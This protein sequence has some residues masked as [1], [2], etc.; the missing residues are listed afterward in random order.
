MIISAS[1]R[2]D[3]P[4]YY[5]EW[6]LNRIK[7]GYLYVRNPMNPRQVSRISLSPEVVDCIV[8]WTKNPE[9]MLA[10]LEELEAYSYYFQF[11]LTGYGGD[12][13]RNV[14]HKKRRMIPVF[15]ELSRRIGKER[16]IWRY[17]PI[18][19]TD[20][21]TPAYHLKAFA[22]IAEAL[23]GC[24]SKCVVSFVDSYVRNRQN[25]K[26]LRAFSLPEKELFVFAKEIAHIAGAHHMTVVS[27]AETM[28]LSACGIGHSC[29]IDK[30]LI[31]QIIGCKI[32]AGKDRNQRKECGCIESVEIGAYDTCRNGC[33]Y[34]YANSSPERVLK[35]SGLYDA[36]APL[37]CGQI[38]EE[39]IVTERKM[40]SLKCGDEI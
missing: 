32:R 29:C 15:Q 39:D 12:I 18:L 5:A 7:E 19:F 9:P 13:E 38:T 14:P 22:Q 6:F 27:C 25:M 37:L 36:N 30:D 16:V 40:K 1:R 20:T 31:E 33:L 11:T 8:F 35:T 28:D 24:T 21:Y 34:C 3:I 10:G 26:A 4:N 23:Q 2:T 17:D